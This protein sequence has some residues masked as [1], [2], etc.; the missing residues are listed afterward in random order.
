VAGDSVHRHHKNVNRDGVYIEPALTKAAVT[1][2]ASG[3]DGSL[4]S[5]SSWVFGQKRQGR[6]RS[7]DR[8]A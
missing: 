1:G 8:I 2:T 6:V 3:A 4:L 5:P 7:A